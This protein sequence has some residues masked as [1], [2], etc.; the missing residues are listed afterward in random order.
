MNSSWIL[1]AA[2]PVWS[3]LF[4]GSAIELHS[5]LSFCLL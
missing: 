1:A 4:P 5:F 3:G 2:A